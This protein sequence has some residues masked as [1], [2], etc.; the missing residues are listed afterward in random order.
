MS[1]AATSGDSREQAE[2][3]GQSAFSYPLP[4]DDY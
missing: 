4:L 2:S 1:T 3:S